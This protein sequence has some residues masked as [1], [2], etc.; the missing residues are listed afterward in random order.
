MVSFTE[1]TQ[2]GLTYLIEDRGYSPWGIVFRKQT[3]LRRGGGPAWYACQAQW[4]AMDP[5]LRS[6]AVRTEPTANANWFHERE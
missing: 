2:A 1:S 5:D 6:W 3:V 4:D